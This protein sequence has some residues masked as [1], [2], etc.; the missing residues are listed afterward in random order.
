MRKTTTRNRILAFVLT[1]AMVFQQA[2][3]TTF[4]DDATTAAAT[5]ATVEATETGSEGTAAVS[6][7]ETTEQTAAAASETTE[8]TS[9]AAETTAETAGTTATEAA[10]VQEQTSAETDVSEETATTDASIEN[11]D[12]AGET[13]DAENTEGVV[14]E[15]AEGAA[16]ED[17]EAVAEVDTDAAAEDV[18]EAEAETEEA[19]DSQTEAETDAEAESDSEEE[20]EVA[21]EAE[22]DTEIEAE[23]E[24]ET[25]ASTEEESEAPKTDFEYADERVIIT[26]T[27][28][29]EAN[30][31]QD[32]ELKADYLEPDSDEYKAAVAAFNA[33]LSTELG[34]DDENVVVEYTLYDIYFLCASTGER[35]E[36]EEGKVTVTM[37]FVEP[38]A[39]EAEG[40]VIS[41]EVVHLK[42]DGEAEIVTDYVDT[43]SE[44]EVTSVGFTQDSFS[45]GGIANGISLTATGGSG[46]VDL[47]DI[48]S[49]ITVTSTSSVNDVSRTGTL[50]IAVSYTIADSM[51]STAKEATAWTYDL[52]D[53]LSS[54][55][56]IFSSI[57]KDGSGFIFNGS[58]V[59]GTYTITDGVVTFVIDSD[60]LANQDTN[61]QGTFDFYCSIDSS[62]VGTSESE[63][64]SF[65][66]SSEPITINFED[67]SVTAQKT[68]NGSSDAGSVLMASDGT[69]KYI[70]QVTPNADLSTL[71][72]TDTLG[73][74]QS[75]V[76]STVYVYSSTNGT[77]IAVPVTVGSDGT[78]T[79]DVA[80]VMSTISADTTYYVYY[81]VT[82]DDSGWG[83]SLT[84]DASWSWD[85]SNTTD[86]NTTTIKPYK[87]VSTKTVEVTEE[88]GETYYTYTITIGDGTTNLAG[89][90]ITDIISQNQ[91]LVSGSIV[92]TSNKDGKYTIVADTSTL[93][94]S[95]GSN[96]TAQ[97]F[98]YTFSTTKEWTSIYTIT[99]K[100][101]LSTGSL[102]DTISVTNKLD[103]NHNDGAPGET[104]STS[105]TVELPSSAPEISKSGSADWDTGVIT[106]T[107]SVYLPS[108]TELDMARILDRSIIASGQ[109]TGITYYSLGMSDINWDNLVITGVTSGKTYA[110]GDTIENYSQEYQ[111][112]YSSDEHTY[113]IVKNYNNNGSIVIFGLDESITITFTTTVDSTTLSNLKSISEGI[114][115]TNTA[116]LY[117]SWTYKGKDS[118]TVYYTPEYQLSKT[119]SYNSSTGIITWTIKVNADQQTLASD[120]EAYVYDVIPAGLTYVSGSFNYEVNESGT[121]ISVN[122][123]DANVTV[124]SDETTTLSVKLGLYNGNY[125]YCQYQTKVNNDEI[126]ASK[127]YTN[128]VYLKDEN[129]AEKAEFEST[130]TVTR[131]YVTKSGSDASQDLITY[132]VIANP[133]ALDLSASGNTLTLTDTLPSEVELAKGGLGNGVT[134][135][136]T[137]KSG[138]EVIG[139][140][141]TYVNNVL[142]VT[143]PDETYVKIQFVVMVIEVGTYTLQNSVVLSG[144]VDYNASTSKY[145]NIVEH[146]ATI[147]GE[148]NSVVVTKYNATLS[149]TLPGA[150]F[151]LY[152]VSYDATTGEI[153]GTT[154]VGNEV[155]TGNNGEVSFTGLTYGQ[156]YY[157]VET[158]APEGYENSDTGHYF[159]IYNA[160]ENVTKSD[161]TTTL[162][163][164]SSYNNV[165]ISIVYG[166]YSFEV[167]D[168]VSEKASASLQVEKALNGDG[169][170]NTVPDIFT[171]KLEAVSTTVNEMAVADIPMP[172]NDEVTNNGSSVAFGSITY[173]KAGEYVYSITET[174]VASGNPQYTVNRT[175]VIYAKVTVTYDS[176]KSKYVASVEYYTDVNLT[177]ASKTTTPT[178][179]N[180]YDGI[181][182]ISGTK[183]WV[184]YDNGDNTRP[185]SL[186]ITLNNGT[187][188]ITPQSDDATANYYIVWT[189]PSSGNTW[190][191]TITNVPK[192]DSAGNTLSYTVTETEPTNYTAT[193]TTVTGTADTDG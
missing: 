5:E 185:S 50:K 182:S 155:K 176:S 138:E 109:D 96:E 98:S 100:T 12:P 168:T 45:I 191:Y 84:N 90:T 48:T 70:V 20:S 32:A 164:V 120:F 16:E 42:N 19:A 29:E 23:S 15:A 151:T 2:G 163:V 30:L 82:V 53:L 86:T 158:T 186:V 157:I 142:T 63:T 152:T 143:I 22:T 41:T 58:A 108:G 145:Y 128:K 172:A 17:T 54:N 79:V 88:N 9:A 95:T 101:K 147:S 134:V 66:G 64:I 39:T 129:G 166:P 148:R 167:T 40:E 126:D 119:G 159:A 74:G 165:N 72:L 153:T 110:Q 178:I 184:D 33:Q 81:E 106:W 85:G 92:M 35:I 11:T 193:S 141:Y 154:P 59:V 177:D 51:L 174:E 10:E 137:D 13:A 123:T 24:S 26:A 132:T 169:K 107:I 102:T 140:S 61:V 130:V 28:A 68:V 160:D 135:S 115:I 65:P 180:E 27:A 55:G 14:E 97:L 89:Y 179:T 189:I 175:T 77:K 21:A 3:I 122:D 49:S 136:F 34:A 71:T 192:Y 146:S 103:T 139:C 121:K 8:Q 67:V 83:T 7:D 36:P 80:S 190:S 69:L 171:F 170:P 44:G 99:Y 25:E 57:D 112:D 144:D 162:A 62:S 173:D 93:T 46:T 4:A 127:D 125:Y 114:E 31:P 105:K 161:L 76:G 150:G 149:Q 104:D 52:S 156:L 91:E 43:N 131:T 18:T 73:T 60:W 94:L 78:F 47:E 1:F 56:G 113:H 181:I 118:A 111:T 75:I 124:Q 183:T 133:E 38:V 37:T 117:D 116:E 187:D 6:A 87:D 188:D